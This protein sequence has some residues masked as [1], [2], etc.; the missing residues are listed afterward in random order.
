MPFYLVDNL[1]VSGDVEIFSVARRLTWVQQSSR[2]VFTLTTSASWRFRKL[3]SALIVFHSFLCTAAFPDPGAVQNFERQAVPPT[4]GA[5]WA[6][7]QRRGC[8][9]GEFMCVLRQIRKHLGLSLNL[10]SSQWNWRGSRPSTSSR[11]RS[12]SR[13]RLATE[14]HLWGPEP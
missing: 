10:R 2:A 12:P 13:L 1:E 8:Q 14:R 6:V 5:A 7:C 4:G 9:G 3:D 11:T